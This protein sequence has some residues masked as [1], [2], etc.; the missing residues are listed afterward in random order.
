MNSTF[1][2]WIRDSV[3]FPRNQVCINLIKNIC[4]F[5]P[6]SKPGDKLSC[7][8][9]SWKTILY[10][11]FIDYRSW[12]VKLF[13]SLQCCLF[14]ISDFLHVCHFPFSS[15]PLDT[16]NQTLNSYLVNFPSYTP[17][18]PCI[19]FASVISASLH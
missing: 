8:M 14:L 17:S 11:E 15:V 6:S 9:W 4:I 1:T 16:W 7:K 2:Y 10:I 13:K 18:T 12:I 19:P 3:Y 5:F